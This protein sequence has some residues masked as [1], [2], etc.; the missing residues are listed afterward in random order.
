M[1]DLRAEAHRVDGRWQVE[2]LLPAG[3]WKVETE[4]GQTFDIIPNE[5]RATLRWTVA[6]NR[7]SQQDRPC[8]FDLVG[9]TAVRLS[10]SV[11]YPNSLPGGNVMVDVWRVLTGVR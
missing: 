11:V 3:K 5:P 1:E 8:R 9:E 10:F 6:P 7:W 4:E 2:L